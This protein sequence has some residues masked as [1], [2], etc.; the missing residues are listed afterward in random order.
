MAAPSTPQSADEAGS[1]GTAR[2]QGDGAGL[3]HRRRR[4]DDDRGRARRAWRRP[5]SAVGCSCSPSTPPGAWPPR[6]GSEA[7]GNDRGARC[8]SIGGRSRGPRGRAV[9]RDARHQVVVGRPHPAPRARRGSARHG[10]RQ[11]ALPQHHRRGS[12]TATT[13]SPWSGCTSCT[14]RGATTWSSS[15]PRRRATR[16]TSSTRPA[17]WPSSSA[18]ACC[19]GSP[20]RT[21]R[22]CSPWRR[23]PSTRW[24]IASSAPGSCRTSPSSS[25]CSSRWRR[26]R[27][28]GPGRSSGCS[29][30]RAPPSVSSRRSRRRRSSSPGSSPP[31]WRAAASISA[32]SS[33]T[34]CCRSA[35][36]AP[37]AATAAGQLRR[38][39]E[40]LADLLAARRSTRRRDRVA[41]VLVEVA[42]RFDDL[43][44]VAKREAERLD[45]AAGLAPVLATVPALETDIHDLD[46]LL[47]ARRLTCWR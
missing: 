34:G 17:A 28:A 36:R 11:P 5:T 18:A 6:W 33:P 42:D 40:S 7:L 41:G 20:C 1:R 25:C 23:S 9:G 39:A 13:T 44:V 38:A 46:G 32:P 29:P 3:R 2:G 35:L 45:R 21:A 31:P 30:T 14:R 22:S 12:C 4:Q 16:S 47:V 8:R 26:V 19:A 27:R 24:P 15:T 10:P 43:A 37:A